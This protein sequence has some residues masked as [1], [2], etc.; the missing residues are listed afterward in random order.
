MKRILIIFFIFMFLLIGGETFA[1]SAKVKMPVIKYNGTSYSLYYSAKS[2]ELNGYINEYYKSRENYA[3]WTEL[4]ALH[5]YPNAFYPIEHAQ[6]F[7]LFLEE[8]GS[9]ANIIENDKNNSAILDFIIMNRKRLPIILEYNIFRYVKSPVCG[10]VGLQYARRYRINNPLDVDRIIK[11]INKT[12]KKQIKAIEK[13][14]IPD[15]V[16]SDIDKGIYVQN[17][18]PKPKVEVQ[19]EKKEEVKSEEINSELPQA[20]TKSEEEIVDKTE[21]TDEKSEEKPSEQEE[22]KSTEDE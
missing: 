12:K 4:V 1:K 14:K 17:K 22:Q 10:T 19:E 13:I 8:S 18:E 21:E 16:T 7:K 6:E 2:K 9:A 11:N 5:H 3:N 15:I 20:E